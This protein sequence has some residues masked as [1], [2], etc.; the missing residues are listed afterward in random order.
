MDAPNVPIVQWKEYLPPKLETT[1]RF[2]LGM[3]CDT[4]LVCKTSTGDSSIMFFQPYY[5]QT[6]YNQTV[7]VVQYVTQP[8]DKLTPY[9][10]DMYRKRAEVKANQGTKKAK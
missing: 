6:Q 2:S 8:E 3:P 9:V 7:V 5:P 10:I 1:V 4:I